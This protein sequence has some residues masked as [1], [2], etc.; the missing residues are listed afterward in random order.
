M[1]GTDSRDFGYPDRTDKTIPGDLLTEQEYIEI[2][3]HR[4]DE[5]QQAQANIFRVDELMRNAYDACREG[6]AATLSPVVVVQFD[7][8]GG[9]WTLI[10]EGTRETIDMRPAQYEEVKSLCHIPLGLY[11]IL[12]PYMKTPGVDD[13]RE[14]IVEFRDAMQ[15]VLDTLDA[16]GLEPEALASCEAICDKS[17]A[18][19]E[20][21]LGGEPFDLDRYRAY[22][23]SV[24]PDI[25]VLLPIAGRAQS[26]EVISMLEQWRDR[27][28]EEW[29]SLTGIVLAPFT[30]SVDNAAAQCLKYVMDPA[31]V[32]DRLV[33]L[34]GDFKNEIDPAIEV[35]AHLYMDRL[36]SRL[37]FGEDT[38]ENRNLT[39][40]LSSER[41][42]VADAAEAGV[43]YVAHHESCPRVKVG[44]VD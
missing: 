22:T 31:Y 7:E 21:L 40:S 12:A 29:R 15:R 32:E 20:S 3:A 6:V 30:L 4:G 36:V 27:L 5:K 28:G 11:S 26:T 35:V 9:I 19:T 17:V 39:R 42:L 10:H 8:S 13:W 2:V 43:D 16:A 41:D 34:Q 44:P 37:V 33:V 1:S 25:K 24:L 14:D 18:Y 23:A 38:E